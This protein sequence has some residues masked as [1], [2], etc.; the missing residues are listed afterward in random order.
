MSAIDQNV[1]D[2][3][4]EFTGVQRERL[5][6]TSTLYGDLGVDGADGWELIHEFGEKFH[7][8]LSEFHFDHHFG[9][10]G[11]PFYAPFMW[12]WW[13]ISWPLR[14]KQSPEDAAGL[15]AIR[16]SDLILAA[17]SKKWTNGGIE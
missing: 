4:A 5:T 12:L 7:V 6:L 13:L 8:D 9:P 16:I 14:K 10:E 2:F 15:K 11:L 1:L 17:E 3:V